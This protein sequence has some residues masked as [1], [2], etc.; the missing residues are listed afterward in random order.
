MSQGRFSP[1]VPGRKEGNNSPLEKKNNIPKLRGLAREKKSLAKGEERQPA[2]KPE[3]KR[4]ENKKKKG[5]SFGCPWLSLLLPARRKPAEAVIL[6]HLRSGRLCWV[7]KK[8][9][10]FEYLQLFISV[11]NPALREQASVLHMLSGHRAFVPALAEKLSGV[12]SDSREPRF[13]NHKPGCKYT[14]AFREL[15]GFFLRGWGR[16]I[17]SAE[18]SGLQEKEERPRGSSPG[19]L[20]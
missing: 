6:S 1:H 16:K 5:R 7:S 11:T 12:L 9:Q 18:A 13:Q 15:W 3:C 20:I 2:S 10:P 17:L 14:Y 4:R 19:R 8:T